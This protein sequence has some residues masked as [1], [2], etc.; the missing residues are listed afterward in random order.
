MSFPVRRLRVLTILSAFIVICFY[1]LR[2]GSDSW[3]NDPALSSPD[4]KQPPKNDGKVH[5]IPPSKERYPVKSLIPFPESV[6]AKIPVIQAQYRPEGVTEKQERL[7]RQAEVKASFKHSWEGYKAHAWL[8]D[9]VSPVSGG[10]KDTF[11]GWAATLVDA[12]DTLWIMGMKSEFELA[13]KAVGGIDFTTTESD[14]INVFETTI[15]YLGGFLAAYDISN[16]KYPVLLAK[17]VEVGDL[18]MCSFDTPNRMPIT[19][20]DWQ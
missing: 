14:K 19:R 5:W 6:P 12:L 10:Y 2:T 20:W 16:E 15:R 1:Y 3:S 7:R 8:R 4:H 17:A 11:G 18:L 9:E 13:V